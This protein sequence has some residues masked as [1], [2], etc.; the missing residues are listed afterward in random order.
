MT[1]EPSKSVKSR[2]YL[3]LKYYLN[4]HGMMNK[5]LE[6]VVFPQDLLVTQYEKP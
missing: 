4:I 3:N 6:L 2:F 1:I 5:I